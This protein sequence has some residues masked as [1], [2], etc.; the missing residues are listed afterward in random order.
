MSKQLTKGIILKYMRESLKE[1]KVGFHSDLVN[2]TLKK[3]VDAGLVDTPRTTNL[4][5][6]YSSICLDDKKLEALIVECYTFLIIQGIIIPE[7]VT[8]RFGSSD[9]WGSFR[10]TEYGEKWA[11]SEEEPIP[12]DMNGFIKFLEDNIPGIDDVV[13]QYVSEALNT[14]SGRYFFASAVMLGAAAEKIIYLLAEAIKMSASQMKLVKKITEAL[15]RRKLFDLLE[16]VS[17]TLKDLI[18]QKKIPYN[19]HE[20]SNHYLL[21]LFNAI[22]IQ[23]NNAVHPVSSK[24]SINELRLLILSF[25]HACRKAYDFL[26]WLSNNKI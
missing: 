8:P 15:E 25:P 1:L 23:R 16:L 6:Y 22:R 20:G 26:S 18:N 21:S 12:E 10:I 9:A 17:D 4:I 11:S 14:F 5:E 3:M 19:I 24:I 7:P 2:R 13:I